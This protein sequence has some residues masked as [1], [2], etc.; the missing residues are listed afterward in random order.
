MPLADEFAVYSQITGQVAAVNLVS[1]TVD[2]SGNV[3]VA[4]TGNTSVVK[5]GVR[6]AVI[7]SQPQNRIVD[8]EG[9]L[10]NAG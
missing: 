5:V 7:L 1:S 8:D 10:R 4:D 2:T 9:W 3:Y 6:A